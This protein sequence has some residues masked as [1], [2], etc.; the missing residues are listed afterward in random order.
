M[1]SWPDLETILNVS[2]TLEDRLKRLD[3]E[4]A[5][6]EENAKKFASN[7]EDLASLQER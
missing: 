6:I 4:I 5:D 7:A 3:V 2:D 1:R